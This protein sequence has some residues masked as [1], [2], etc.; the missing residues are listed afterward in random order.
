MLILFLCSACDRG[1]DAGPS[2]PMGIAGRL[3]FAGE[4]PA[5]VGQVAV[6]VYREVLQELAD[7]FALIGADTEVALR[8][9]AYDYFVPIETEGKY[10][11]VVVAWRLQDS[12]WDFRLLLGCYHAPGDTLPTAVAVRRGEVA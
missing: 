12:F 8:A 10:Q 11:W 2:G 4:W 5:D 3:T 7:F 1:L 6:A 9:E